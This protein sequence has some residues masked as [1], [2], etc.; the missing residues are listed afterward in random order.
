M[1]SDIGSHNFKDLLVKWECAEESTF[2]GFY[3]DVGSGGRGSYLDCSMKAAIESI[4]GFNDRHWSPW[5]TKLELQNKGLH[6]GT[7]ILLYS[8]EDRWPRAPTVVRK[9]LSTFEI[10]F[11]SSLKLAYLRTSLMTQQSSFHLTKEKC[12]FTI[13]REDQNTSFRSSHCGAVG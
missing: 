1:G 2:Q 7:D 8:L 3:L 9:W 11:N 4:T 10:P 12:L 6:H 5:R 13:Q